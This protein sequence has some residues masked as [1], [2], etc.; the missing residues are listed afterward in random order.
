[1]ESD[2]FAAAEIRIVEPGQPFIEA[3]RTAGR[4]HP[5]IVFCHVPGESHVV[6]EEAAPYEDTQFVTI[7]GRAVGTN[8]TGV[9]FRVDGAAYVA[10]AALAAAS[11]GRR[12]LLVDPGTG[13]EWSGGLESGLRAGVAVSRTLVEKVPDATVATTE[14]EGGSVGGVFYAGFEPPHD[15]IQAA[16][17]AKVPLVVVSFGGKDGC[18]S[19]LGTVE[20]RMGEAELRLA[21]E[22]WAETLGGRTYTFGL[23]SG[24]VDFVV[25]PGNGVTED[26]RR[27][28]D[29]ARH[30]VLAGIAEVEDLEM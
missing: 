21:R 14:V 2:L 11:G 20:I 26:V 7:P 12:V 15:L 17:E 19:C 24:V 9:V 1:M 27:A 30:D 18:E 10:G 3:L 23:G 13:A 8:V 16:A 22:Q 29:N 6:V 4:H 5:D 25:R 28:V